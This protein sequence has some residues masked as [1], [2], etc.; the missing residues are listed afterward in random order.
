MGTLRFRSA[1]PDKALFFKPEF[2]AR[3]FPVKQGE[4]FSRGQGSQGH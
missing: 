3:V 4:I 2:L 1:D